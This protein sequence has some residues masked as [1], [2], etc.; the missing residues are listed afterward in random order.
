V[1][2]NLRGRIGKAGRK[3]PKFKMYGAKSPIRWKREASAG[4]ELEEVAAF[5]V[6]P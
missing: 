4:G 6:H 2:P 3:D 1:L 5:L